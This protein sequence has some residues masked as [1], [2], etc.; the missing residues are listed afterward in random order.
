MKD[1]FSTL[2]RIANLQSGAS[3]RSSSIAPSLLDRDTVEI[4]E[5]PNNEL[6]RLF[7]RS[8]D[9]HKWHHYFDVYTR[10]FGP[11]RDHPIKMLEIGVFRGGS[12]KMWKEWFHRDS[13]IV[14]IDID[15]DCK[16]HEGDN[17][18]I[19]IG[20]QSDEK[21]LREIIEEF[22]EFDIILDDGGHTSLQQI[23]SFNNFFRYSLKNNGIYFVEDT[24]C[25]FWPEYQDA[26]RSFFDF[27]REIIDVMHE[28]YI[29][30]EREYTYRLNGP[31]SVKT[32]ELSYLAR[33]VRSVSIF[34]SIVVFEK[35]QR[36]L[37]VSELR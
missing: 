22:G 15:P 24:Q 2:K 1:V 32:K 20:D 11:F 23:T 28:A 25:N 35:C 30:D 34:D 37:P 21:F 18:S 33:Y 10:Y 4:G 8:K 13:Q 31:K 14:G 26:D 27:S 36:G 29:N 17:I 12:L 16:K 7:K 9:V 6:F 5:Q 3:L 19:R